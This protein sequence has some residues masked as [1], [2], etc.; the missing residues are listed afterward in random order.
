MVDLLYRVTL[1][2]YTGIFFNLKKSAHRKCSS[3][4]SMP[5]SI[6]S[7]FISAYIVEAETLS[8]P[9]ST[10]II[11][12]ENFPVTSVKPA[13]DLTYFGC[14]G[15]NL[16]TWLMNGERPTSV[17]AITQQIKPDIY[18]K[19]DDEATIIL[20]YPEVQTIIQASWNWNYNRKDMEVYCKDGY[21][22]CP[23]R[24]DMKIMRSEKEGIKKDMATPLPSPHDDP[25]ALLE[26]V[27]RG[28]IKL[29]PSDLSAL[30]N[31]M[32]VMEILDAAMRSAESGNQ[33]KLTD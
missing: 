25:F 18:P 8:S 6:L 32:V 33:I 27:I 22:I 17:T 12:S 26:A 5:V 19:V 24:D 31:N 4:P 20:T 16:S 29:N 30:E 1:K 2:N 28:R 9:H 3:R 23:N 15:A 21:I 11:K 13:M 10:L 14:Y 7:A